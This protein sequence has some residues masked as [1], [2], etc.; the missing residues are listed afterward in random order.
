MEPLIQGGFC[1][2][3]LHACLLCYSVQISNNLLPHVKLSLKNQINTGPFVTLPLRF[4]H[5]NL[6]WD[7][8][9]GCLNALSGMVVACPATAHTVCLPCARLGNTYE[10]GGSR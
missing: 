2:V 9:Y 6:E 5:M 4:V 7:S 3:L 8:W 1:V 10:G